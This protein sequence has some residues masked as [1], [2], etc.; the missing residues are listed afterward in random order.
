MSQK[1]PASDGSESAAAKKTRKTI[2]LAMKLEVL[3]RLEA[4]ERAVDIGRALGLPPTTV[5]TIRGNA[6]KIKQSARSVTPL[7]AGR[8]SRTRSSIMENMERLLAVWIED[9]NQRQVP[10]SLM[11]IQAKAKSL[12]DDLQNEQGESSQSESFNASRGWFE[13]FKKRSYLHSI[14]VTGEVTSAN[15]EVADEFAAY[16]KRIIEEGGYSPKQVFNVDETGLYWKRMPKKTYISREEKTA[17]GFKAAKDRLTV[18]LGGN[19]AG[20]FKFK[21]LVVHHSE[22]PRALRGYSKEHCVI[23]R[24]NKKAWMTGALFQEWF[25]LYAIP[26]WREYCAR[27][28]IAFKILLLLDNCPGHPINLDDL[29]ENVKVI[30]LPPNVNSLLQPM[31]QGVIAAFKAY[32]LR[33]TF[34]QLLSETDGENAPSVR[35]FWRGYNIL[36]G[37][38]NIADSWDEVTSSCLNGVWQKMWPECVSDHGGSHDTVPEVQHEILTLAREVGFDEVDEADVVELLKSHG[39]ELSNEDLMQLESQR[40]EEEDR[41]EIPP[42][43]IL[44]TKRLSRA[45]QIMEEA[46]EI[47]TE[48]DPNR[49]RSAKVNRA[50]NDGINCY[51]EIY[52]QKKEKT[53]QQSL[54]KFFKVV[55]S[56]GSLTH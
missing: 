15:T 33:R 32:Y 43:Q 25:S 8:V 24:S 27:E 4:G 20:D 42:P 7:S 23:W 45:F 18:L 11:V 36:K 44:S 46:M 34:S 10:L 47:F 2:T 39:E 37:I 51:K 55:D 40:A 50:I 9:Q 49:E 31:A 19:A 53:V 12:Y 6:E 13:R 26:A 22:T 54:D 35:E 16:L 38:N 21:P 41:T 56:P 3:K 29:S 30:F 1:R 14:K 28:N 48:D 17:P 5:R 52:Q